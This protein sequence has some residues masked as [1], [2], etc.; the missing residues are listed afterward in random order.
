VPPD[1]P[2]ATLAEQTFGAWDLQYR[3]KLAAEVA[4]RYFAAAPTLAI[5]PRPDELRLA[6][7]RTFVPGGG[8]QRVLSVAVDWID[9]LTARGSRLARIDVGTGGA[10]RYLADGFSADEGPWA[11]DA[12]TFAWVEGPAAT[13]TI[14][15]LL[16]AGTSWIAVRLMNDR[17]RQ[18]LTP[19]LGGVRGPRIAIGTGWRT[20]R[21]AVASAGATVGKPFPVRVRFSIPVAGGTLTVQTRTG[22]GPWLNAARTKVTAGYAVANVTFRTAGSVQVRAIWSGSGFYGTA[23]SPVAKVVVRR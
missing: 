19:F 7:S 21:I 5:L 12:K 13:A 11:S 22:S 4:R 10:R 16:P 15:Y 20:Y 8:D 9:F 18:T 17:L 2:M 6:F 1:A 14:R 3:P 23:T